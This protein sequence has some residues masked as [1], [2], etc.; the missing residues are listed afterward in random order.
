MTYNL[1]FQSLLCQQSKVLNQ[2]KVQ[3][4]VRTAG[5][6][7]VNTEKYWQCNPISGPGGHSH[8]RV[9]D[10]NSPP[11]RINEFQSSPK[12]VNFLRFLH[13]CFQTEL[14]SEKIPDLHQSS[15]KEGDYNN[16][17]P[18]A[19][20]QQPNYLPAMINYN[21]L[22]NSRKVRIPVIIRVYL[23]VWGVNGSNVQFYEHTILCHSMKIPSLAADLLPGVFK[24]YSKF[25]QH[26]L[27]LWHKGDLWNVEPSWNRLIVSQF[28]EFQILYVLGN[29]F[30]VCIFHG[31]AQC[32]S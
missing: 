23:Y 4:Q 6:V 1:F 9:A 25:K 17:Q 32:P 7:I 8:K 5:S 10:L 24:H 28:Q 18:H 15:N 11:E 14:S 27:H 19:V 29:V 26:W 2:R 31:A 21:F 16:L 20:Q 12:K 30:S 13:R 3:V 22:Q